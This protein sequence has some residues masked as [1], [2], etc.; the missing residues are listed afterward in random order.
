MHDQHHWVPALWMTLPF[1]G[2]LLSIAIMPIALPKFWHKLRNQGIVSLGF[3]LPIIFICV[4]NSPTALLH[5]L[6]HYVSFI[7]L[8]GALFVISGGIW[9]SGSLKGSPL[10]NTALL[11]IGAILSNFIGTTGSSMVLIR[12]FLRANDN[13]RHHWHLPLFFIILVS[14]IGG[15]LTPLGDPPLFLGFLQGVPFF[16]TLKLTPMWA[17][18]SVLLLI[19]FYIVDSFMVKKTEDLQV[20]VPKEPFK[21]NGKRNLLCL[22][23]VIGAVFTPLPYREIIMVIAALISLKITPK[24]YHEENGF[25]FYPI[26]EVAILFIGIFIA[27]VPALELLRLR[28]S[29]LGVTS[30]WQFFWFTGTF[31]AF[32]DNAPTY[33]TFVAIGQGLG[34]DGPHLHLPQPILK[35]ISV[36]AVFFGACTYIGNAPNFM[37]RSIAE[38]AGW[39]VPTF[40]GY[41]LRTAMILLPL[42]LLITLIFF[43]G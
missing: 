6:E 26:Q 36:G 13:R 4:K 41:I 25:N 34:L 16:W 21:I 22:A 43:R 40:F 9:L 30:L 24:K 2:L 1:V 5:S 39:K 18:A 38:M 19:L 32:L 31:S 23:A 15:S 35:A 28:G 10:T 14:N 33:L 17:V 7:I 8:L 42:F 27:M 12:P 3:A 20:E 11:A 29:E 37:V